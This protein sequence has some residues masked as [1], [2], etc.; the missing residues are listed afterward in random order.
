MTRRQNSNRHIARVPRLRDQRRG[1]RCEAKQRSRY[2]HFLILRVMYTTS[3]L[4]TGRQL[5]RNS[6][7]RSCN[8]CMNQF[9]ENDQ[10]NGRMVTGSCT[11]TVRLHTL[12]I[13]C[14]SFWPNTAPLSCSSRHT[15]QISHCVTFSYS[16]GLRKLHQFEVTEDIKRNSMK[17][18]S[19]IPKEEFVKCFQQ[20]QKRW[21]KCVAAEGNY[22]DDN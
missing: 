13:L 4:L 20:W 8:I 17:T 6:T 19:D 22:V 16:Q 3:T 11:M 7:W 15:H 14:R 18:L 9:A 1:T 12:N 5:S 2:R 21:A 10:K